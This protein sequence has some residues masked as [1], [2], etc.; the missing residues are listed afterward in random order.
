MAI[1]AGATEIFTIL[2]SPE[3]N[4]PISNE[5]TNLLSILERTI[6]IFTNDVGKNDLLVPQ[7]YNAALMYIAA[8]KNKMIAAG[9]SEAQVNDFFTI[10]GNANPFEGKQPLKLFNIRPEQPLGGGPGGL[11]F[12]P[13]EMKQMLAKGEAAAD[14]FIASLAPADITWV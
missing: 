3:T 10:E 12:I 5:L 14:N 4:E 7:Q 2:L 9:L 6:D 11:D 8:V 13:E 1:D